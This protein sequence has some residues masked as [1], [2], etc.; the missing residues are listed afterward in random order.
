MKFHYADLDALFDKLLE[1]ASLATQELVRKIQ[2]AVDD[3]GDHRYEQGQD[4][5]DDWRN[6]CGQ[7]DCGW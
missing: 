3:Y 2:L 1:D 4:D 7:C 6:D 5:A